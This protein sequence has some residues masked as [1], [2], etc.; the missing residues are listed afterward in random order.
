MK[1]FHDFKIGN[2]SVRIFFDSNGTVLWKSRLDDKLSVLHSYFID[3]CIS[4]T[5]LIIIYFIKIKY[6]PLINYG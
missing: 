2:R 3:K 6:T 5:Y 1:K 4:E